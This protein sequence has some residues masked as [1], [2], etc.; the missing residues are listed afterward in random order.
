MRS[1]GLPHGLR[2]EA[3]EAKSLERRR[4]QRLVVAGP[5]PR[6]HWREVGGELE[7]NLQGW[8]AMVRHQKRLAGGRNLTKQLQGMAQGE[9]GRTPART[10][11]VR[12]GLEAGAWIG[13]RC[14]QAG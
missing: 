2:Q 5:V 12:P 7:P 1:Q 6:I 13:E 4:G 9:R 10:S 14:Q 11:G 8:A 3:E